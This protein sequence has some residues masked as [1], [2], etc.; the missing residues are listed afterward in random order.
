MT[1]LVASVLLAVECVSVDRCLLARLVERYTAKAT[2]SAELQRH[3]LLVGVPCGGG[4]GQ[5]PASDAFYAAVQK[6]RPV[7]AGRL[8]AGDETAWEVALRL[9]R[10]TDG[11]LLEDLDGT[12]AGAIS[13]QPAA[14][15]RAVPRS[16]GR[17]AL[18]VV[19]FLGEEFVD[20]PAPVRCGALHDRL[21]ALAA[22]AEADLAA[23][24]SEAM[25]VLRL[26]V[27]QC[28]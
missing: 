18:Q 3:L 2:A 25:S 12:V 10:F 24:R 28:Q 6:L 4:C 1:G 7:L 19:W 22:V 14:F 27:E 11:G 15:L 17:G 23:L 8:N 9:R 5:D 16:S 21:V 13:S 20:T 26:K